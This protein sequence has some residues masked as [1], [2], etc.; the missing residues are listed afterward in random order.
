MRM[1]PKIVTNNNISAGGYVRFFPRRK[2][3][4]LIMA[5]IYTNGLKINTIIC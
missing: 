4:I 5:L 2:N 3:D 1:I